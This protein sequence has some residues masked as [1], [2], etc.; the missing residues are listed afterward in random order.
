[1]DFVNV[2]CAFR[3]NVWNPPAIDCSVCSSIEQRPVERFPQ[4]AFARDSSEHEG[5]TTEKRD[6]GSHSNA[7]ASRG[8]R[9]WREAHAYQPGKG[10][11]P[12][13]ERGTYGAQ[14]RTEVEH[15]PRLNQA[16]AIQRPHR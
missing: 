15:A 4:I 5:R 7:S 2:V 10:G 3:Q 8:M 6:D 14:A 12:G 13:D 16:N 1:M 9:E 11:L